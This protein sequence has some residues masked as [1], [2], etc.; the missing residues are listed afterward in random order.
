MFDAM[1]REYPCVIDILAALKIHLSYKAEN[2]EIDIDELI[3]DI[4]SEWDQYFEDDED[5]FSEEGNDI[6]DSIRDQVVQVFNS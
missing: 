4:I 5:W 3:Y 6:K 2:E 1:K